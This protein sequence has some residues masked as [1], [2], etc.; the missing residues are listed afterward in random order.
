MCSEQFHLSR[1]WTILAQPLGETHQFSGQAE[2]A[3]DTSSAANGVPN[4]RH[5]EHDQEDEEQNLGDSGCTGGDTAETED[6]GDY[7]NHQKRESPTKQSRL[8]ERPCA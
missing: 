6:R 8:H 3:L 4:Q 5:D 2:S 1:P 7:R